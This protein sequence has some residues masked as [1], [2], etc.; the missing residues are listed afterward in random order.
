MSQTPNKIKTKIDSQHTELYSNPYAQLAITEDHRVRQKHRRPNS[1][2]LLVIVFH[3]KESFVRDG[4]PL[5]FGVVESLGRLDA[6]HGDNGEGGKE[7]EQQSRQQSDE[8]RHREKPDAIEG[9]A[10]RLRFPGLRLH[11]TLDL[12]FLEGGG[13]EEINH[14][15]IGDR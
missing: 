13:R 12:H 15:E 14:V 2:Y 11:Q 10:K 8:N 1:K 9:G 5:P 4:N 6:G 7:D 3:Q